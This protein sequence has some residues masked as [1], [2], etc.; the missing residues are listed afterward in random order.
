[1]TESYIKELI[2]DIRNEDGSIDESDLI[3]LVEFV[4]HEGYTEGWNAGFDVAK[5]GAE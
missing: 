5:Y 4:H 2:A 3:E 1:M